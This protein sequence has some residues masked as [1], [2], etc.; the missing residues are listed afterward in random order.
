MH[1]V[2][3]GMITGLV[4]VC[5]A[6]L[7]VSTSGQTPGGNPEAK[8]TKNPVASTPA[9]ITAGQATYQKYCKFCHGDDAKGD[10]SMAPKDTH[11]PNLIDNVWDRGASDGEIFAVLQDGAGPKFDMKGYKGKMPDQDLWNVIN[12]LRSIGSQAKSR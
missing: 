9:S 8:K 12:Y 3:T 4:F 5:V 6:F 11:P 2:S 10:G 7:T 1:R